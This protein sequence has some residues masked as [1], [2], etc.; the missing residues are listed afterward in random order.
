MKYIGKYGEHLVLFNLLK[1]DIEAYLA[2]K[3]NQEDYD[4]TVILDDL[5]VK[6]IQVKSTELSSKGTNNPFSGTEKNYD[7]LIIVIVD[8]S[9]DRIF[10]LTKEE[11]TTELGINKLF[12][13]TQI[14]SGVAIVKKSLLRHEEKW[15]KIKNV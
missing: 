10:I 9:T 7:F 5:S 11:A 12:G 8:G 3:I 13:T 2:V 6:R 4:I 1:D 15:D 14:E